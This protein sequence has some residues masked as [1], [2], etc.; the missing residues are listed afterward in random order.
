MLNSIIKKLNVNKKDCI[1]IGDTH[2]D[3]LTAKNAGIDF[4]FAMWGYGKNYN[5]KH[6]SKSIL[7]LEKIFKVI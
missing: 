5:Y 4:M 7:E 6:K 3:Y 1:Y 2:I